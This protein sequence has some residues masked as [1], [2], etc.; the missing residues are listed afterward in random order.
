ML[1]CHGINDLG[2]KFAQHAP[3][4]LDK[5][6]RVIALDLPAHGRSTGLHV[7]L[8]SLEALADAVY[9]VLSDVLLQDSKLVPDQGSEP[10]AGGTPAASTFTQ[11]RKIF[12]AGQS[13]GGF[14]ATLTCIKYGSSDTTTL[15]NPIAS[16]VQVPFRPRISG[17]LFLCPMLA[18]SPETRPAFLV[19]LVARGIS[20]FAGG[21]PLA[22]A[23]K[24][25]NSEDP[26]IEEEFNRD[27]N[28]YHGKLRVGTG[29][30]I[31]KGL[32]EINETFSNLSIPFLICHGTGDRVVSYKGSQKLL[33]EANSTDKELKLYEG[34]EHIL[35]RK[36]K[37][38]ADDSR[39]Q[40]VLGDMLEW[41]ERH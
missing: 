6:Y 39:R 30:A 10:T 36:G 41:L 27:P 18:I 33:Q 22:A 19:E 9:L 11:T 5:G 35:L 13:L 1:Y 28:T 31:L 4:F 12:V 26:D 15:P 40:R 20:S 37:D 16:R 38:E 29:L 7:Y 8:P 21:L 32:T 2:G 3:I 14:V 23:N 34:Y 17:G 24:G 25:K